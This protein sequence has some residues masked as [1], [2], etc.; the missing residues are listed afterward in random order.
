VGT[1]IRPLQESELPAADRIMR[2]A[3]GTFIGLPDPLTFLGD[4]DYVRSRWLADPTRAFAAEVDGELAGSN[5]ATNWGSVGFFGPLTVRPDLWDRGVGK[6]LMEPIMAL[7]DAWGTRQAGL[8]TFPHSP[9]H[10]GLYQ[11][12][13]FWPRSLTYIMA[14]PVA[15]TG[16]AP[17]RSRYSELPEDQRQPVLDVCRDVTDAVYDGLDL[18]FEI[19][20]VDRQKLGDTVLLWEGSRLAGFAVCH[21][22]PGTEAGSGTCYVKFAAVRPGSDAERDFTRLLD[23]CEAFA[24]DRGLSQLVAGVN[25]ARV[26]ATRH[27][28]ARGFR[29]Q[30]VGIAMHRD[31]DPGYNRPGT[32]VLDDWR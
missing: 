24:Q 19:V 28:A 14:K 7:F 22:G 5:F 26:E 6:A 3:F 2:L 27:L 10:H 4:G 29:T 11:R 1:T 17:A 21:G 18:G 12:F 25:T 16:P 32:F 30:M 15:A 8:F 31:N 13:G 23:A 9:K 20:A